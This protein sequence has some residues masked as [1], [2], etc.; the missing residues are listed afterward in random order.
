MEQQYIDINHVSKTF[1]DNK[2][3]SLHALDDV[4]FT[5]RKGEI[6]CVV[7]ASGCGKSTLL[8]LIAG[9]DTEYQG[10]ITVEAERIARPEKKRGVVFQEPRLFSWLTVEDNIAFA[11]NGMNKDRKKELV[12]KHIDLVGLNGFEKSY[13]RQLSGGMAQ[14]TGIA[15]ALVNDPPILLLD[16]PFSALDA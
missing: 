3:G 7:G 4:T 6:V 1:T 9:L 8:R 10:S 16:E 5:V 2:S 15:R 13:P 14:R 11:L 12:Q